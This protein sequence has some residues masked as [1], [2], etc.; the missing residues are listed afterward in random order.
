M[1]AEQSI[2]Y[3]RPPLFFLIHK[4]IRYGMCHM[5]ASLQFSDFSCA[6]SAPIVNRF[7]DEL[8]QWALIHQAVENSLHAGLGNNTLLLAEVK[9][10]NHTIR[11][12]CDEMQSNTQR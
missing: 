5:S 12:L 11:Q 3:A 1:A 6:E 4:S 9:A 7:S 8:N 2:F 10:G